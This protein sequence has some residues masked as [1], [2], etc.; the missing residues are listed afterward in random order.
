METIPLPINWLVQ[1]LGSYVVVGQRKNS[2][3]GAQRMAVNM[4]SNIRVGY[5]VYAQ[6]IK[7]LKTCIRVLGE[8]C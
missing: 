8:I 6:S 3:C 2:A 1:M 7:R 5:W 4:T